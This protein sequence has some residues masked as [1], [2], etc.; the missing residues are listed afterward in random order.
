MDL[1]LDWEF[2][3]D[4]VMGGVSTGRVTRAHVAGRDAARLTGL[5][6]LENDGGFVQMAADLPPGVDARDHAGLWLDV[7][8]DGQSYDLRLRTTDLAR[9][10]QSFRASFAAPAAWTQVR[11]PFAALVPH[12]TEATFQPENLRRIGI[13]A[14]G[15]AG[16]ADVAVAGIGLYV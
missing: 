10:W 7:Y 9:P 1:Q 3:A 4:T 13:L 14:I 15:Q 2:V 5:V 8:G 6:S 11:I 12:K 16:P